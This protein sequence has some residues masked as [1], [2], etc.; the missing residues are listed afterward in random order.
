MKKRAYVFIL[1]TV[2][3]LTACDKPERGN[4]ASFTLP[5]GNAAHGAE[6]FVKYQCLS[7]HTLE[8]YERP[9]ELDE[10]GV[11]IALG[12]KVQRLKNYQ[13][14]VMSIINPSHRIAHGYDP[15]IVVRSGESIM[16]SYNDVMTVTDL[17]DLVTFLEGQYEL[18]PF[19]YTE[20][21]LYY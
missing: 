11:S 3:L 13:D 6:L 4:T 20:Y 17:I 12:G 21:G 7:C 2:A 8:G 5:E 18:Q 19:E 9:A 16:P 1:S 10:S 14:L 15:E